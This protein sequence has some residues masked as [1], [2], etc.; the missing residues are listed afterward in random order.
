MFLLTF[1]LS[2][3]YV[4]NAVI[5]GPPLTGSLERD[6]W[7]RS[8][9]TAGW[10]GWGWEEEGKNKTED[11]ES[12]LHLPED[13]QSPPWHPDRSRRS[14]L[15]PQPVLQWGGPFP[16]PRGGRGKKILFLPDSDA[17]PPSPVPRTVCG[18]SSSLASFPSR[19]WC[20]RGTGS[21]IPALHTIPTARSRRSGA[22]VGAVGGLCPAPSPLHKMGRRG[23]RPALPQQCC[24]GTTL[25]VK[26]CLV[27]ARSSEAS[28]KG[29][30]LMLDNGDAPEPIRFQALN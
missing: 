12:Q 9:Q 29:Q 19:P 20:R 11:H 15:P 10:G 28:P 3:E 1:L 17:S 16:L 5:H 24:R 25:G 14:L 22:F 26:S 30:T 13:L 2:S 23:K 6:T 7:Q 18:Y 21:A 27:E 8:W 4:G